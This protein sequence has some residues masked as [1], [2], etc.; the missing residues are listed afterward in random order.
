MGETNGFGG[1]GSRLTLS[2]V[3]RSFEVSPQKYSGDEPG[4]GLPVVLPPIMSWIPS[5]CCWKKFAAEA[6]VEVARRRGSALSFMVIVGGV[7]EGRREE[8]IDGGG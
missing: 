8:V 6:R 4:T 2:I 7:E 3:A 5:D 1:L